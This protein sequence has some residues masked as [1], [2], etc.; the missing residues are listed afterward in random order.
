MLTVGLVSAFEYHLGLLMQ[1]IGLVRPE[2]IFDREKT[3]PVRDLLHASSIDDLKK[4]ILASEVD[5]VLRSSFEDQIEWIVKRTGTDKIQSNYKEW[6][7]LIELLER[8][9]LFAH[10][11]GLINSQ[12]L[13][14]AK[15]NSFPGYE[16][17]K[18]ETELHADYAY[19]RR[20]VNLIADFGAKLIQVVWRKMLPTEVDK[21]DRCVGDF[22]YELLLRGKYDLA[23]S[24]LEFGATLRNLS[25]DRTR[26]MMIVN[27]ANAH[28][29]SGN[30]DKCEAVLIGEDWSS[31][32]IEFRICIAAIRN[33]VEQ[34]VA[35]MNEFGRGKGIG[36]EGYQEWPAFFHIRDNS[37]FKE[38]V[39][40]IF[41]V[42]FVPSAREKSSI[43]QVI[44]MLRQKSGEPQ[45]QISEVKPKEGQSVH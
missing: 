40:E 6:P 21:A 27:L 45:K 10:T 3:L 16:K 34:T 4:A 32:S 8:R 19:Y 30:T 20:A 17:L 44:E 9:N 13:S 42:E 26:R 24:I 35:L 38:T 37:Q 31:S 41:G 22:G 29:L 14:A 5:S 2:A 15:K 39:T 33:D 12:Y 18:L 36:L 23:V 1:Q 11:A 7:L 43:N 28:K 25:S